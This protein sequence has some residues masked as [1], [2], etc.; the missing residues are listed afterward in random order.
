MGTL[1]VT[2]FTTPAESNVASFIANLPEMLGAMF[3]DPRCV[4]TIVEFSD[5]RYV[6]FWAEPSDLLISEVVSNE[7]MCGDNVL[8]N[9]DEQC[10]R[11][12]GWTDPSSTSSPNWRYDA[13]DMDGLMRCVVMVSDAVLEVLGERPENAVLV[14]SWFARPVGAPNGEEH[15]RRSCPHV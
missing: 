2:G 4:V 3:V 13:R 11:D 9:T 5:G 14:R 7:R 8:S 10:L 12:S 1:H 15:R 6:Q